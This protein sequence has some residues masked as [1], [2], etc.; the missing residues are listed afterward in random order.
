MFRAVLLTFL[1]AALMAPAGRALAQ[2]PVQSP[3]AGSPPAS[4]IAGDDTGGA[5]PLPLDE[6]VREA[7][8]RNPSVGSRRADAEAARAKPDTERAL[9]P[10]MLEAQAWQWPRDTVNPGDV[11]WMAMVGQEF[12]GRGKRALRV[13]MAQREASMRE[14]EVAVE[15]V[16]VAGEVRR[17]Y[18]DLWLAR[19]TLDVYADR[20]RLLRQVADAA[21]AK[22]AAGRASQQDIVRALVEISRVHELAVMARER[23]RMARVALNSLMGRQPDEPIGEVSLPDPPADV[24]GTSALVDL[25]RQRHPELALVERAREV[26]SAE[27]DVAKSDRRPNFVVQGGYM[28]M[29][30]MRDAFTAR[31]GITWPGAPWAR[32]GIE[33]R[34][35]EADA[36][37]TAL[38]ARRLAVENTLARMAGEGRVRALAAR[39]R[40]DLVDASLLPQATHALELARAEYQTDQTSFLDLVEAERL[41]LDLRLD[42]IVARADL[43]RALIDIETATGGLPAPSTEFSH[44]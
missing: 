18:V 10:P 3:V 23:A 24:P 40:A 42:A 31:V 41:V 8:E 44:E 16:R 37:R 33:A 12:P 19:A 21:E 14:G 4:G 9:P 2:Q 17:A 36:R 28:W 5:P 43:A 38:D 26:V 7:L 35:R 29:P 13:A 27:I 32:R 15:A 6:A 11:Q 39:E 20:V 30:E 25:A 1:T 34:V 22:Y